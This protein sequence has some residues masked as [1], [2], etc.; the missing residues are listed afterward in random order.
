MLLTDK[1]HLFDSPR[2]NQLPE[3]ASRNAGGIQDITDTTFTNWYSIT[4]QLTAVLGNIRADE[5]TPQA[6]QRFQ[7]AV[8][9]RASS[10]TA[11]AY[12][13]AVKTIYN[14]LLNHGI[15]AHNPATHIPPLPEPPNHPRAIADD[16]YETLRN[17][18]RTARDKAI[19]DLLY[20][21][22]CR[23]GELLTM[24]LD[25]IERFTTKDGAEGLAIQVLGKGGKFRHVYAKGLQA[26]SVIHY[27]ENHRRSRYNKL[28]VTRAGELLQPG[29]IHG[30]IANARKRAKLP[31]STITNAH[32]FRHAAAIRWLDEGV[33][34]A[35]VSAWLG[36]SDPAFTAKTYC[37]RTESQLRARFFGDV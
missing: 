6:L 13:R 16:T 18:V 11:N 23:I 15:V 20:V 17:T 10:R 19:L 32:S 36:H 5:L 9:F 1:Q 2:L 33:D 24:K 34:L 25:A 14:R 4:R 21:S 37:I 27:I 28:F 31:S 7:T 12:T 3:I 30:I 35:T 8:S 22:G 26:Q 29:T